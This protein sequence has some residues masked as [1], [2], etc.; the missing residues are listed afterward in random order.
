[1][2]SNRGGLDALLER[3]RPSVWQQF[4]SMPAVY[5]AKTLYSWRSITPAESSSTPTTAV[6]IS[7]THNS[8]PYIPPGDILIH[9]G[10]LIQSGSIQELQTSIDWLNALPHKHKIVVAGNHDLHLDPAPRNPTSKQDMRRRS[11][12]PSLRQPLV[13]PPR[14]L[15]VQ[16]PRSADIWRDTIPPDTDI[17]VTHTPPRGH[18]DL[19]YFGRAFLLDEL[20]RLKSKPRLHVFGHVHEGYGQKWVMFDGLQKAFEGIMSGERGFW[21]FWRVVRSF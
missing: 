11:H 1:M 14:R 12:S 18:L 20:W 15:G 21:G 9:A 6:C 8:Q 4:F 5:I 16:Y 10:D 19:N 13:D 7:D 17:L 3:K 2:F